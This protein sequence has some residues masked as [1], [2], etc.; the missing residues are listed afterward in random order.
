MRRIER[1]RDERSNGQVGREGRGREEWIGV[2]K[3]D[4]G[5]KGRR[6][7]RWRVKGD[8]SWVSE[9]EML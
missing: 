6:V 3:K 7:G 5:S 8:G 2:S 9:R 4:D 1:R